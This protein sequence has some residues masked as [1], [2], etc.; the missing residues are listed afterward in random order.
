MLLCMLLGGCDVPVALGGSPACA[1]NVFEPLAPPV[2]LAERTLVPGGPADP[3]RIADAGFVEVTSIPDDVCVQVVEAID[4]LGEQ[5]IALDGP[6]SFCRTCPDR[7]ALLVGGGLFRVPSDVQPLTTPLDVRL[8]LRSCS[9][10]GPPSASGEPVNVRVAFRP[11]GD[12]VVDDTARGVIRLDVAFAGATLPDGVAI[13]DVATRLAREVEGFLDDARLRVDVHALCVANELALGGEIV[14]SEGDVGEARELVERV[15]EACPGFTRVP[16]DPRLTVVY[17]PCLYF[18]DPL[19]SARASLDGYTT[20]VPG[21]VAAD[22]VSDAI[23][24]G[25]GCELHR[26][27]DEGL[28]HGLARDLAHEIGHYLGL[29][30]SV[31]ADGETTDTL[32]DTNGD[33][34]MNAQPSLA[35][36]RGLSPSQVAI[37]RAHPALRWPR[38]GHEACAAPR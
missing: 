2:F 13:A 32:A 5:R 34:L 27:E 8:G 11:H 4:G 35:T 1:P 18:V 30:H 14:V 7:T 10:L 25:G 38:A 23:M 22:G 33:D 17:V 6:S 37:V 36:A 29:F 3:I 12:H 21:G 20:H 9:T 15:R 19:M 26:G 28:P 24:I 16:G 31:E